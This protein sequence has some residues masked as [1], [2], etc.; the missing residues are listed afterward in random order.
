MREANDVVLD[1]ALYFVVFTNKEQR[2]CEKALELK[3]KLGGSADFKASPGWLKS[4]KSCHGIRELQ[5]EDESLF[6]DKNS[7]T[8][9]VA[10]SFRLSEQSR[11]RT[12]PG[13]N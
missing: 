3:E 1:R 10:S 6:G 8:A 12:M 5:I 9:W 7:Y 11:I 4:F 2:V 13:P